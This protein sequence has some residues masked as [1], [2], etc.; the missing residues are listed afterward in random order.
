MLHCKKTSLFYPPK[1]EDEELDDLSPDIDTKT[2]KRCPMTM[3]DKL[4]TIDSL[5]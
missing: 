2:V 4:F 1:T 3:R 5:Q